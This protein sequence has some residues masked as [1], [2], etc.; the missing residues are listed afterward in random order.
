VV[1]RG[2]AL[3]G[4]RTRSPPSPHPAPAG[5]TVASN[6]GLGRVKSGWRGGA[7]PEAGVWVPAPAVG[8]AEAVEG[9]TAGL[10]S[11]HACDKPCPRLRRA[12][13]PAGYVNPADPELGKLAGYNAFTRAWVTETTAA[14]VPDSFLGLSIDLTDIE[15]LAHDDYIGAP[16]A[17]GRR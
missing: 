1:R 8:P 13:A 15:G 3:G 11:Q 16:R 2:G 4:A 14:S 10:V 12:A 9:H 7:G 17:Q 5:A 6:P